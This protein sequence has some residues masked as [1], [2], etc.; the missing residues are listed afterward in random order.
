VNIYPGKPG[1]LEGI[2]T[3]SKTKQGQRPEGLRDIS[4]FPLITK[5][6]LESG[7]SETETRNILGESFLRVFR[8]ILK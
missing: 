6:L 3:G 8:E 2:Y 4:C 1:W 5:G 7:F